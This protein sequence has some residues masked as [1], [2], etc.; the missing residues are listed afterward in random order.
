MDAFDEESNLKL[1]Y[2]E[3]EF[4]FFLKKG[5]DHSF[6][7][8]MGTKKSVFFIIIIFIELNLA[9]GVSLF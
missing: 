2:K 5:R 7:L 6:V 4:F 9:I 3:T 1:L 8:R